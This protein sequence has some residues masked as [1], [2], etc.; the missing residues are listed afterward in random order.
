[1]RALARRFRLLGA[2]RVYETE[3]VGVADAPRFLN[4]AVLLETSLTPAELKYGELRKVEAHLGRSRGPDRN[5]PRTI[6]IDIALYDCLVLEDADAGLRLPD[7]EI[8]VHAYVAC[9]LADLAPDLEHPVSGE[10]L[11][12]IAQRLAAG[13]NLQVVELSLP[14]GL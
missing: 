1:M 11:A 13:T 12:N 7:P 3:A 2:S 6:D 14:V 9:P 5:A 4:A 10:P 8:L